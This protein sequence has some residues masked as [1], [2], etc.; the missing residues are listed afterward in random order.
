MSYVIEVG[1][2]TPN[3]P[4]MSN[5]PFVSLATS[6]M[7]SEYIHAVLYFKNDEMTAEVDTYNG[8]IFEEDRGFSRDGW[9]FLCL[10][11]TES[12]YKKALKFSKQCKGQPYNMCAWY[13]FPCNGC[14]CC[15]PT[16]TSK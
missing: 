3:T 7:D 6:Y 2:A 8:V 16:K 14:C 5:N 12:G 4:G 9:E 15:G 1:F 10:N 13:C 11:V